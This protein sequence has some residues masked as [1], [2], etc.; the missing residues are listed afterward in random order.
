MVGCLGMKSNEPPVAAISNWGSAPSTISVSAAKMIKNL[1][2]ET[3]SD[4]SV[5][6]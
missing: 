5:A 1:G 3:T 6:L 4:F 2:R